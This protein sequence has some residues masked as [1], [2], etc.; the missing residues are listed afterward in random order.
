VATVLAEGTIPFQVEGRLIQELGLR[1][2]ARPEV[3]LVELIKNSYDADSTNCTVRL[4]DNGKKLVIADDGHGMTY[5]DFRAKWM[6]IA[7]SGKLAGELSPRYRRP[8]TGAKGIGRFAVRYLGDHLTLE[9]VAYDQERECVTRLKAT[10]V[11]PQ[12]DIVQDIVTTK[13][14]FELVQLPDDTPS[15]TTLTI[16]DLRSCADFARSKELR[17]SVLQ[18]ISPL[19]GLESGKFAYTKARQGE[20]PG[21]EV[22]LPGEA[23]AQEVGL[24]RLVL[25][26][27][28]AR[29]TIKLAGNDL[30][31]KVWFSG[32][33]EPKGLDIKRGNDISRGFFA[34]IRHFPR[35]KGVFQGKAIHGQKAWRWVRDNCGVKL[36]DH[37]FH[38]KP[39]GFVNNDW[40]RLDVDKAHSKRDWE[41]EIARGHF[42]LT[43]LERMEPA[44]N[45]VLNLPYNFQLV[46][47]VFIESLRDLGSKDKIDLVPAMD[48]EG[49]IENNAFEQLR[50]FVRA[51]IEFLAHEDKAELNRRIEEEAKEVT[52]TAREEIK[53]AIEYIQQSPTLKSSDKAR[54]VKQYRQLA[55]RVEEQEEYSAQARRSLMTMSML[56]VVAGFMTH[57]STAILEN[58]EQAVGKIRDLARRDSSLRDSADDLSRRLESF[59]GYLDYSRGFVR[60]VRDQNREAL[61]AA[62]QVRRILN[63][64]K[65]FA[66]GR[67]IK[68]TNEIP[69]DVRTPPLP[70]TAYSG[71]LLNLYTNALKAVMAA[72]TSVK[73][74][75]ICFRAWN[76][77]G[78]HI[79]EVADNG[80]GIPPNLRK[81]IWEPLF[82]TTSDVGNPLGSGMGLGLP[83]I[84]QVVGEFGGTV[85][86]VQDPPPK[87]TTCFRVE[88]PN[89]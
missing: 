66:D 46:G 80:V 18:I 70:V 82:T 12:L 55:D 16:K 35:R 87:F 77:K 30:Q 2:V 47:A 52:R 74:P 15:G 13:V 38:I 68:V 73:E 14:P 67:G 21:F 45:P 4:E 51:G 72:Q 25:D 60:K 29:L 41:T 48:R 56:G 6:R 63:I 79:V 81:R 75:R 88:F 58:L 42:P 54:I 11:W 27:Y 34:D 69:P 71:V 20:D 7:T 39:Y 37:G 24:A 76:A 32:G 31:F 53:K 65:A 59:R 44:D 8:L 62:G 50:S 3:A 86:L 36:V 89:R 23:E 49:L 57:E 83:L 19:Q 33:G 61:S 40:L 43:P 10:F 22:V 78:R 17:D 9:S 26:N 1:L 28:W 85:S 5:A 64:F 84:K